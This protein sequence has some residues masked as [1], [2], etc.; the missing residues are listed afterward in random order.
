MCRSEFPKDQLHLFLAVGLLGFKSTHTE[1]KTNLQL[2]YSS[3]THQ[4]L[5]IIEMSKTLDM[6]VLSSFLIIFCMFEKFLVR[7]PKQIYM[8]LLMQTNSSNYRIRQRSL[9]MI[10]QLVEQYPEWKS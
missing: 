3:A 9:K 7:Y 8:M 6:K 10:I 5:P 4:T 1:L 2:I